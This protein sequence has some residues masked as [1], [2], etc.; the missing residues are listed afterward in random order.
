MT[1]EVRDDAV[2]VTIDRGE[3]LWIWPDQWRLPDFPRGFAFWVDGILPPDELGLMTVHGKV[4][5]EHN[6][7]LG[8]LTFA[9]PPN[10]ARAVPVTRAVGRA[11][12][13]VLPRHPPRERVNVGRHTPAHLR[14]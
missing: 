7:D 11:P 3:V 5:D 2:P 14:P 1:L 13:D 12:V 10:Q 8:H 9:L 4:L 6:R